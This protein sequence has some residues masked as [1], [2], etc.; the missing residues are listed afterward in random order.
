MISPRLTV[1]DVRGSG[2]PAQDVRGNWVNQRWMIY[3][4]LTLSEPIQRGLRVN[5]HRRSVERHTILPWRG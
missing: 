2:A 4:G 1:S 3:P 5:R